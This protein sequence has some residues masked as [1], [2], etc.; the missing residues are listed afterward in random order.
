[1]KSLQDFAPKVMAAFS[2]KELTAEI[3]GRVRRQRIAF[4]MR[5][6]DLA[7]RAGVSTQTVKLF[8]KGGN[9]SY[10]NALRIL[11]ALGYGRDLL[12][13]LEVPHYPSIDAQVRFVEGST[14]RRIRRRTSLERVL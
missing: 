9:V 14:A 13:L 6:E 3:A 1:M 10:E 11:I 4:R 5:Q 2:E 12:G 8:E 7:Q